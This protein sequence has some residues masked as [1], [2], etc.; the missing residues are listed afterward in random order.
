MGIEELMQNGWRFEFFANKLG[1]YT[2]IARKDDVEIVV[3]AFGWW[4][5]VTAIV[6]KVDLFEKG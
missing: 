1:S 6:S 5:A 4:P 3:D 2:V